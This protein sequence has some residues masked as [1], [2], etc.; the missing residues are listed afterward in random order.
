MPAPRPRAVNV[1]KTGL[2][3]AIGLFLLG[4]GLVGVLATRPGV[5][6]TAATTGSIAGPAP[7]MPAAPVDVGA[8]GLRNAGR[9]RFQFVDRRDP[10]RAA[11][12]LE[13]AA[14]EPLGEGR[15]L[16]AEPRATVYL[17]DGLVAYVQARRGR[18]FTPPRSDQ[19]ESGSFEGGVPIAVFA[20]KADGA[21]DVERDE[22]MALLFAPVL[23]FNLALGEVTLPD[24]FRFSTPKLELVGRGLRVLGDQVGRRL[25]L[26]EIA[27]TDRLLLAA[28]EAGAA[29]VAGATGSESARPAVTPTGPVL[30]A[31]P[32]AAAR[33]EAE[34]TPTR[35]GGAGGAGGAGAAA[36]RDFYHAVVDERFAVAYRGVSVEADRFE[37]WAELVGGSLPANAV[38]G[39]RGGTG[40]R[41]TGPTRGAAGAAPAARAVNPQTGEPAS[42]ARL[43]DEPVRVTWA[44][45]LRVLPSAERPAELE[46]ESVAFRLSAG[47]SGAVRLANREA[48]Q[49]VQAAALEYGATSRTLALNGT[50]PRSVLL[51]ADGRGRLEV[52]QLSVNLG[53]GVG[54]ARGGGVLTALRATGPRERPASVSWRD[55]ADVVLGTREQWLTGEIREALFAGDVRA[56]SGNAALGAGFVRAV[57]AADAGRPRLRTLEAREGVTARGD[58]SGRLAAARLDVAFSP[59]RDGSDQPAVVTATGRVV[60]ER[61]EWRVDAERLEAGLDDGPDGRRRVNTVAFDRA[62]RISGPGG[63]GASAEGVRL[64]VPGST[65]VLSGGPAT[66][67]RGGAVIE[68]ASIALDGVERRLLVDGPGTFRYRGRAAGGGAAAVTATWARAL[69][70]DDRAGTVEAEG[71]ARAV[72]DPSPLEVDTLTAERLRLAFTPASEGAGDAGGERRLLRAV[73]LAGPAEDA[74]AA[75]IDS[76]RYAADASARDGRGELERLIFVE[77]RELAASEVDGTIAAPG[78]GR[79]LIDDRRAEGAAA[80]AS[81]LA[82]FGSG[83]GTSLFSWSEGLRFDRASG[84]VELFRQ[85]R[86]L[87]RPGPERALTTLDCDR[88][89]AT[90]RGA[91]GP[92]AGAAGLE[93]AALLAAAAEGEVLLQNLERQLRADTLRFDAVANRAEAAAGA[94]DER[95]VTLFDPAQPQPLVARRLIWD[96][97]NNRVTVQEPAPVVI[98]R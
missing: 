36:G 44:G 70:V 67:T 16:V 23:N 43:G 94:G 57:F 62:V 17:D 58:G 90:L 83:R 92:G 9:A 71:T 86:L 72:S 34:P 52:E 13:W 95:R 14:L 74:E 3:I 88:L 49:L 75:R 39:V 68:G 73:A 33:A 76:R 63:L 11:G 66:L 82:D 80:P 87:H 45:P 79:L 19:P 59:D 4:A 15:S 50:G 35:A 55:Q 53:S 69:R 32:G 7:A 56:R 41:G 25:S 96:L 12:L 18:I 21:I 27:E 20:P 84:Q 1:R 46:T 91:G 37:A 47:R 2:V 48:G 61:D 30:A 8:E 40:P 97:G 10:T 89:T 28:D 38:G 22:P 60:A 85:V 54:V 81:G 51:V 93:G 6:P 77:A 31:G 64:G 65:A 29:G 98:P 26:I 24:H 5:R 78:A 42:L